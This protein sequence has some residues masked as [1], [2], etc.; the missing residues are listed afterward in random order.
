MIRTGGEKVGRKG[1][2]GAKRGKAK[3]QQLA[4]KRILSMT[5]SDSA[6]QVRDEKLT[7]MNH[8][9]QEDELNFF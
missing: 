6:H 9:P 2:V 1:K 3:K 5:F 7:D 8:V 4:F